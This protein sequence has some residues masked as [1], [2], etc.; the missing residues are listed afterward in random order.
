[1]RSE[2]S[3]FNFDQS[4][5]E[6]ILYSPNTTKSL[7]PQWVLQK[8]ESFIP[9][10]DDICAQP[11]L[12][13][14][15]R[16]RR[17]IEDGFLAGS[18]HL[19]SIYRS[20]QKRHYRGIKPGTLEEMLAGLKALNMTQ[21][22]YQL[23][24]E[25]LIAQGRSISDSDGDSFFATPKTLDLLTV[26]AS[27][28][29]LQNYQQ[30]AVDALNRSFLQ[31]DEC[32][33]FL[34]MP[35][36]SGKTR[37]AVS[38]LFS[39]M[40][41][42]GYQVLWL[43]HRSMLIDQ[44]A[45]AFYSFSG[46]VKKTAPQKK[47][48]RITCVSGEHANIRVAG[49]LQDVIVASIPSVNRNLE[50]LPAILGDKVIVVI[51]EAH[52]A[53]APSY[54]NIISTVYKF[55]PQA[56]LLGLTATPVRIS[57]KATINLNKLFHNN[58]IYHI[59]LAKLLKTDV[60]AEP[61]FESVNTNFNIEAHIDLD[62]QAYI[63]K[64][65]ELSAETVDFLAGVCERNDLIVDTYC[66]NKDRYG[67]T[68]IFAM[69]AHHCVSLCD[70]LNAKG[71]KCDYLYSRNDDNTAKIRRFQNNELEVLVNINILTEGSDIPDIQTVFLTRPTTSDVLL[72]QMVGRALRGKSF[73]GTEYAYIV[74][75]CDKWSS[76][77]RWLNPQFVFGEETEIPEAPKKKTE[78]KPLFPWE[79][80]RDI[81]SGISYQ[82]HGSMQ[83]QSTLPVGWYDV[84]D[85][86]GNDT[87]VLV[88]SEQMEG[89]DGMAIDESLLN[90]KMSGVE[91]QRHYFN[92]F[93]LLPSPYD[94]ELLV[95]QA[96]IEQR[97]PEFYRF[98]QRSAVDAS[99]VASGLKRENASYNRIN[100]VIRSTCTENNAL[101]ESI[102]GTTEAFRSRVFNFLENEQGDTSI[103][104]EVEEVPFTFI[105]Y[106]SAPCY[107][108]E[109]LEK[110]QK[111]VVTERFDNNFPRMPFISWT[112]RPMNSYFGQYNAD[113][114][115]ILINCLLNS[116]SI[117]VEVIK[118]VIYHEM[119][120][121]EIMLHNREFRNKEHLYPE[122]ARCE[123]FLYENF[124]QFDFD[125]AI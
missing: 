119:L 116:R 36:G 113:Y 11:N 58:I 57:D 1:M 41:A 52:H 50:Y 19:V 85:T 117:P 37:T 81:I 112:N 106:D 94:L 15:K 32:A 118:F 8:K 47:M 110:L 60:L 46:I 42:R 5:L 75:F 123:H 13:F 93:G 61:K 12:L 72:M 102:Y 24:I 100:E 89:F 14:V 73:G 63:R 49:S 91:L 21:T 69:N 92:N 17:E 122:F 59:P 86:E 25:A 10:M 7:K 83:M 55:R 26:V 20:L 80:F 82:Y 79:M 108:Q 77:T 107:D 28:I 54:R 29:S 95:R 34:V 30:E 53:L 33:G 74:D 114:D 87:N 120:H 56:K 98:E 65:G 31:N 109:G 104:S 3:W 51:D 121:Q 84:I 67:K 35:T 124:N 88:F 70:A 115:R 66:K 68:L 22:L 78:K 62:E 48:L 6:T 101:I 125:N 18:T 16:Y 9:Y 97:M 90:T 105:E 40:I 44:S 4:F 111:Q 39:K 96:Q 64:W 76:F 38:F 2:F 23:Y 103:Y 45:D 27:E 43:A 71:V 99:E